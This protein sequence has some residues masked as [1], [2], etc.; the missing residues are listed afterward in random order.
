MK[1]D[2]AV[3]LLKEIVERC[4]QLDG[5]NFVIM[6]PERAELL[7]TEGYELVIRSDNQY[8]FDPKT[9]DMFSSI[10]KEKQLKVQ[11]KDSSVMF[12]TFKP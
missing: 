8:G 11:Q 2:Y 7:N 1:L 12:F 6:Q 4:P 10:G 3:Q 5:K 9:L